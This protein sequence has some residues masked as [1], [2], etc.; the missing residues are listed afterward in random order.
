MVRALRSVKYKNQSQKCIEQICAIPVSRRSSGQ[1]GH[2]AYGQTA[3]DF[4]WTPVA[5]QFNILNHVRVKL[6]LIEGKF[7][8]AI[9]WALDFH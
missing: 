2:Q 6:L 9:A 4:T 8:N 7:V 5:L 1:P 3:P